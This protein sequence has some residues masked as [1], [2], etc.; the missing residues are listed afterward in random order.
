[1]ST[2]THTAHTAPVAPVPHEL[3]LRV[4]EWRLIRE[5]PKFFHS[6]G[7][8]LTELI[9]NAYRAGASGVTF[10]SDDEHKLLTVTDDG[11]GAERPETFI[12]AAATGWSERDVVDPAGLGFFALLGAAE[13]VRVTSRLG[14]RTG[15]TI[16][17]SRA[18]FDGAP[19]P[20]GSVP[21]DG[22][23]GVTVTA[24]L[25][26][27]GQLRP[28]KV[29]DTRGYDDRWRQFFPLEVAWHDLA[30]GERKELPNPLDE[31]VRLRTPVGP[32][33]RIGGPDHH[34]HGPALFTV[35]EHRCLVNTRAWETLWAE[36][37]RHPLGHVLADLM[38]PN[39]YAW[40]VDPASGV[41]PKLPDRREVIDD[42]AWR[43]AISALASALIRSLNADAFRRR[44]AALRLGDLYVLDD[45]GNTHPAQWWD[46][47]EGLADPFWG[48]LKQT[49]FLCCAG[50]ERSPYDTY[51]DLHEEWEDDVPSV[52]AAA[53]TAYV[54]GAVRCLDPAIV[55]H[56]LARAGGALPA[57]FDTQGHRG[58]LRLTNPRWVSDSG[59]VAAD[60]PSDTGAAH[61][62]ATAPTA[63]AEPVPLVLCDRAEVMVGEEALDAPEVFVASEAPTLLDAATGSELVPPEGDVPLF[64]GGAVI[65][66]SPERGLELAR[67]DDRLLNWLACYLDSVGELCEHV[68]GRDIDWAALR[69]QLTDTFIDG[70]CPGGSDEQLRFNA[71]QA[72]EDALNDARWRVGEIKRSVRR[73]IEDH[74]ELG[75][76]LLPL[77]K[78]AARLHRARIDA[79]KYA[80]CR[81]G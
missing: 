56:L 42:G 1:M 50:Y 71:L 4:D 36:L 47:P 54:R 64:E 40:L 26:G 69:R 67:T 45:Y 66:A 57:I 37:G 51:D 53:R 22:A 19:I 39:H 31:G 30:T 27:V 8:A 49:A 59:T 7:E 73:A 58:V 43:A 24:H 76:E 2:T 14:A 72:V 41:R 79:E 10:A 21:P 13:W 48:R 20:C 78:L 34:R 12:T 32:L 15:W 17:I 25:P 61:R 6:Y 18:A 60:G 74:P 62:S 75:H 81:R 52:N 38:A 35:W 11:R 80:P 77:F 68:D 70:F 63:P 44:A 46:T 28:R 29:F 3:R 65:A 33:V 55:S 5:L 23:S 16:E 9:Q